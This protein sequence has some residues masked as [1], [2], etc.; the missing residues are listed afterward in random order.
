MPTPAP[1][2]CSLSCGTHSC[3]FIL[4]GSLCWSLC[5]NETNP[6]PNL[7]GEASCRQNLSCS[8]APA[9][10]RLSA[11]VTHLQPVLFLGQGG[12]G[13][14]QT[15]QRLEAQ[16]SAPDLGYPASGKFLKYTNISLCDLRPKPPE[17]GCLE[18]PYASEV[19]IQ[20]PPDGR[21]SRVQRRANCPSSAGPERWRP[22]NALGA[23]LRTL[24]TRR[25]SP[26]EKPAP[27]AEAP[28]MRKKASFSE[29]NGVCAPVSN[30][31]F[32]AGSWLPRT[33]SPVGPGTHQ[34]E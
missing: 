8:P 31:C 4:P 32:G 5:L 26:D 27:Q 13:C 28:G 11:L 16:V 25:G 34:R 24:Q 3:F 10:G 29:K 33:V 30:L 9:L 22:S 2:P 1:F 12:G 14:A 23:F 17:P 21:S 15:R 18:V 19:K 7:E 6:L 20:A